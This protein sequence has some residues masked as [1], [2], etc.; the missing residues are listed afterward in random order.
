MFTTVL[1][2]LHRI[3]VSFTLQLASCSLLLCC[4]PDLPQLPHSEAVVSAPSV[5]SH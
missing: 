1:C 5:S 3:T 4:V 2:I